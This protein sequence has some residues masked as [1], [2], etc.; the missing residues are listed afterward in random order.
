MTVCFSV[1]T[2]GLDQVSLFGA[3]LAV[4]VTADVVEG[5][6]QVMLLMELSWQLD[7]ILKHK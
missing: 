3:G 5:E 4:V 2:L 1:V 7:L 6:K